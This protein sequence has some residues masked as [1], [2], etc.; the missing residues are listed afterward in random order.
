M[1]ILKF[2]VLSVT[3]TMLKVKKKPP[4]IRI[5][6]FQRSVLLAVNSAIRS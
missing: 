2:S 1:S 4:E 6:V 5:L 3:E